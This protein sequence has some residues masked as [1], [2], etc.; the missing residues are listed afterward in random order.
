MPDRVMRQFG[1]GQTIPTNPIRPLKASRPENPRSY[2]VKHSVD[3]TQFEGWCYH[4]CNF[5]EKSIRQD[6][7]NASA[8]AEDYLHWYLQRTHPRVDKDSHTHRHQSS[9]TGSSTDV[10]KTQSL[11]YHIT[12]LVIFI[13]CLFIYVFKNC[14]QA[15]LLSFVTAMVAPF[16]ED[17]SEFLDPDE[18]VKVLRKL[19]SILASRQRDSGD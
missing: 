4:I 12:C 7:S 18:A 1:Y 2:V 5:K 8:C 17:V 10:S 13:T 19:A 11:L 14:E 15:R 16:H 3:Q 6:S 9:D